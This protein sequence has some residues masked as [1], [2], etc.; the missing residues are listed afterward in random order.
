[1]RPASKEDKQTLFLE[2]SDLLNSFDS[3][4]VTKLTVELRRLNTVDFEKEILLP[5]QDDGLDTYRK[6]YNEMLRDKTAGTN[7]MVRELFLTISVFRKSI[8]EARTY[9]RRIESDLSSHLRRLGSKCTPLDTKEKLRLL[10][11]FIVPE[12]KQSFN[13]IY[14]I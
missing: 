4:A 10:H 5:Y 2:Y 11:D 14:R 6:E 12:K 9:F 1:M 13:L 8:D 7:G 3:E